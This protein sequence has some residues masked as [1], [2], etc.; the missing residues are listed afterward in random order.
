MD[1]NLK[2]LA[3]RKFQHTNF[4]GSKTTWSFNEDG[5]KVNVKAGWLGINTVNST[6]NVESLGDG[7]YVG[8]GFISQKFSLDGNRIKSGPVLLTEIFE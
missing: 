1:S 7:K 5:S 4:V 8:K 6:I 2:L 3:N